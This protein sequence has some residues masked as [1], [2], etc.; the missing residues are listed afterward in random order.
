MARPKRHRP[1][2]PHDLGP[3]VY[4]P[5]GSRY[6]KVDLRPWGG[7][8][9]VMRNPDA[10]GWPDTGERT[11]QAEIADRWKWSYADYFAGLHKRRVLGIARDKPLGAAVQEYLS[12]RKTVVEHSTYTSCRSS[13]KHLLE[14]GHLTVGTPLP[15]VTTKDIQDV[16]SAMLSKGYKPSTVHTVLGQIKVFMAWT[17]YGI[18]RVGLPRLASTDVRYW[19]DEEIVAIQRA[20]RQVDAQRDRRSHFPSAVLAVELAL[21]SGLRMGEL[22]A[23]RWSDINPTERVVR[24]NWQVPKDSL[25][26]RAL[27]SKSARTVV[28]LP[29]WWPSHTPP[30]SDSFVLGTDRPVGTRTQRNMV[31]RILDTAGLNRLGAGWH[32]FRHTFAYLSIVK[33]GWRYE[34]LQLALGHSSI[35]TT[36][37]VYGQFHVEGLLLNAR[38]RMYNA[39]TNGTVR[40]EAV[41]AQR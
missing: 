31:Q 16:V 38:D 15:H 18:G 24:V 14:S 9:V 32:T 25:T 29:T 13:L 2:K 39:T 34:E 22:F 20:A 30:R 1:H 10:T 19:S 27:K 41:L 3:R 12:Y 33:Y 17:G 36:Q 28:M 37:G 21:A 23:L 4:R 40:P 6:F 11:D 7:A 8:R 35:K 26:L 5:R